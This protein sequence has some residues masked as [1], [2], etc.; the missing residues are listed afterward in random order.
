MNLKNEPEGEIKWLRW[1]NLGLWEMKGMGGGNTMF[2]LIKK[3][4]RVMKKHKDFGGFLNYQLN[5]SIKF[6]QDSLS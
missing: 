2:L 5:I 6:S 1:E 4:E 3:Y